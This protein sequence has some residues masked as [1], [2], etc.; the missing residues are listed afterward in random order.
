MAEAKPAADMAEYKKSRMAEDGKGNKGKLRSVTIE[1][2]DNGYVT[3]HSFEPANRQANNW[4]QDETHVF[5]NH[6]AL[7]AHLGKA[8]GAKTEA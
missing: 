1:P 4:P 5:E 6:Q 8:L 7:L 2:A 3:R